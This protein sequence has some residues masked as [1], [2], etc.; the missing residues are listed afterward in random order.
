MK[1]YDY[2]TTRR[3][4]VQEIPANSLW[5]VKR[6]MKL[7]TRLN[8]WVFKVSKGRLW[9]TF[10]TNGCDICVV[11]TLGA[12]SGKRRDIALLHLPYGDQEILVASQGGMDMA[13]AWY[14]NVKA[15]PRVEILWG[16]QW[17]SYLARQVN[18]EEKAALWPHLLSLYPDFDEYQ[19]RTDRNIPVF[20]CD[21]A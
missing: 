5:L 9:K 11:S 21:P 20:L 2:V 13:P 3:E 14:F 18:D 19:A 15:N 16:G 4:D 7:Y 6:I 8:V 10:P 17:K 1:R 12:K